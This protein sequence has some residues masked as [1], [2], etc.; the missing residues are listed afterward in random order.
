MVAI[1]VYDILVGV[2]VVVILAFVGLLLCWKRQP[3]AN[4]ARIVEASPNH[5]DSTIVAPTQQLDP[6]CNATLSPARID[7][8]T[9][10]AKLQEQNGLNILSACRTPQ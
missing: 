7:L 6:P 10:H 5:L 1:K 3:Q 4:I 2:G 8:A 9:L